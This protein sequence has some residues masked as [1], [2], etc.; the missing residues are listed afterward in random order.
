MSETDCAASL[1]EQLDAEQRRLR[2]LLSGKDPSVL[3][4]RPP[5]GKWSVIE[6]VRHLLF[7]EQAHLGRFIPGGTHM[8]A[9]GLPPSGM[10]GNRR[11]GAA[12]TAVP[13]SVAEV[14]EAWQ[15]AN[16]ATRVLADHGTPEVR[17]A[18]E[19]NLRHLRAHI[20]VIERL[21]RAS[22]HPR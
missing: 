1:L 19:R 16:A 15:A 7:A 20:K 18:L 13:A 5:N 2:E 14:F 8:S 10:K 17:K 21:L 6:N 3:A 22:P 4:E 11:V 12:G 9:Y